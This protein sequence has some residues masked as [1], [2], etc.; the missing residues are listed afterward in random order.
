MASNINAV[1]GNDANHRTNGDLGLSDPPPDGTASASGVTVP[2]G[3]QQDLECD[4]AMIRA[5][6]S[7]DENFFKYKEIVNISHEIKHLKHKKPT[8][9][10]KM[11]SRY[12]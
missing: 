10:K 11:V 9:Y 1:N 5:S 2:E 7:P 12:C 4:D 3:V 6:I 8:D